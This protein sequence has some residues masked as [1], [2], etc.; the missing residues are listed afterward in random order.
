M[1]TYA[2]GDVFEQEV[3]AFF[4]TQ[5]QDGNF[6]VKPE[7]CRLLRKQ[8]YYSR[9]RDANIIFDISIEF[10][11][12]GAEA[13]FLVILIECKNYRKPV[14]VDDVEEFFAKVDQV[15]AMNA[16]AVM[17]TSNSFQ[18]GGLRFAKSKGMGMLRLFGPSEFKWELQ[19]SPSALRGAI[20]ASV[21]DV[22]AGL[23][24]ESYHS[25]IFDVYSVAGDV[26][27]HSLVEFF[28][29]MLGTLHRN[30]LPKAVRA[31]HTRR[32]VE[33]VAP[34]SI[35]LAAESVIGA[36][37]YVA[38]PV[39]LVDIVDR[40][41]KAGLRYSCE[42][43]P[44]SNPERT[45]LGRIGFNPPRITMYTDGP[46]LGD[47]ERFTLAHELGHYFLR[48]DRFLTRETHE[49]GDDLENTSTFPA[50]RDIQRLEWQANFF[51]ACLLLPRAQFIRDFTRIIQEVGVSDRGFGALF[52]DEQHCNQQTYHRVTD[53]LKWEYGVSRSVV[54]FRLIELNLLN[55]SASR[56]HIERAGLLEARFH[57]GRLGRLQ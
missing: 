48:H 53:A 17:V 45:V 44:E 47:R 29:A 54:R 23:R 35:E 46:S 38:G 18:E 22:R 26:H 5:I 8:G 55:D 43:W 13:Y 36:I 39:P 15:G 20:H 42:P 11:L 27:T 50:L 31:G 33:H 30:A 1:N 57:F 21:A 49:S 24:E 7:F 25:S 32:L 51:A 6:P 2:V 19:R 3:F 52:L 14:P 37:S 9:D 28:S 10:F 41:S 56:L 4:H 34:A 12:P 40:E 16:K